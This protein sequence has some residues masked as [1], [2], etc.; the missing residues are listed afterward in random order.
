MAQTYL[1]SSLVM[2]VLLLFVVGYV[3]R[4]NDWRGR[5][6]SRTNLVSEPTAGPDVRPVVAV[7]AFLAVVLVTS[8]IGAVISGSTT[9]FGAFLGFLAGMLVVYVVW[10]VYHIA[11][12]RGLKFAQSVGV[13]LWF[14]GMLLLVAVV[15]KLL[16]G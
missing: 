9:G 5:I 10:G 2:G 3:A 13:G 1:V 11:Q 12:A 15:A 6:A 7:A 4:S 8:G 16:V 14:F